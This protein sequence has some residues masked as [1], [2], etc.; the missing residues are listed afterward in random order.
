V[1]GG[2]TASISII[3]TSMPTAV[4]SIILAEKFG[5]DAKFVSS[6]VL[7]STLASFFSLSILLSLLT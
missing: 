2:S 7:V 3:Q 1:I 6:V 4:V 5:S